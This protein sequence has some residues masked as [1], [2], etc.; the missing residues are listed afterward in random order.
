MKKYDK[1]DSELYPTISFDIYLA[2]FRRCRLRQRLEEEKN[3]YKLS[4]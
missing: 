4:A 1:V 3:I 2:K